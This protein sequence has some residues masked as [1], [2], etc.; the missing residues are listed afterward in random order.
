MTSS[1]NKSSSINTQAN[2]GSI[3]ISPLGANIASG[4]GGAG[5]G[6]TIQIN[7]GVPSKA[8]APAY[9]YGPGDAVF[10]DVSQEEVITKH[11]KAKKIKLPDGTLAMECV[12]CEKQAQYA[13]ANQQDGSFICYG[14]RNGI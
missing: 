3:I 9:Y 4:V 6:G 12:R 13:E 8:C 10:Y 1:N 11:P 14:C 5:V 7:A 2:Q